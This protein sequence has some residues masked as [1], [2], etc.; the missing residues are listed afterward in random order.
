M[1]SLVGCRHERKDARTFCAVTM[2]MTNRPRMGCGMNGE[3]E[4]RKRTRRK[5]CMYPLRC[6]GKMGMRQRSSLVMK[7]MSGKEQE[8]GK[9]V[10]RGSSLSQSQGEALQRLMQ[11]NMLPDAHIAK[12]L[13]L[14]E[15]ALQSI[16]EL[17]GTKSLSDVKMR[18]ASLSQ[19]NAALRKGILPTAG[20]VTWP[21]E[22]F[23]S[24]F[25]EVLKKLEM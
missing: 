15:E 22:P 19:W 6:V 11:S 1:S 12:S 10:D 24:K 20:E 23:R 8:N 7:S 17:P 21:Q 9:S 25:I 14:S 18:L 13:G 5:M 2:M 4:F 3:S 16:M